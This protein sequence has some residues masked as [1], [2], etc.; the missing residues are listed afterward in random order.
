MSELLKHQHTSYI[1]LNLLII[2]V[3]LSVVYY[4]NEP[5]ALM[6]LFWLQALP[7]PEFEA[8]EDMLQSQGYD[9]DDSDLDDTGT[10][11]GNSNGGSSGIL[12]S[13]SNRYNGL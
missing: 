12:L 11:Y 9:R 13:G 8:L 7:E 6:G 1:V 2:I 4:C 5:L 3:I 10:L